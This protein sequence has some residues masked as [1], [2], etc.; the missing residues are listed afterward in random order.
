MQCE[1]NAGLDNYKLSVIIYA[2]NE[3][4]SLKK[5]ITQMVEGLQTQYELIIYLKNE[6]C[7][8]A[9]TLR[10]IT[11]LHPDWNIVCVHQNGSDILESTFKLMLQ[12]CS[13]THCIVWT[14]DNEIAVSSLLSIV[15]ISLKKRDALV[16]AA[17]FYKNNSM[18]GYGVARMLVRKATNFLV[19]ILYR[20]KGKD[21]FSIYQVFP[22]NFL[23]EMRFSAAKNFVYEST[24]VP[25]K[26]NKDYIEIPTDF[27]K[28]EGGKSN[29]SYRF[30][31]K[32]TG[33]YIYNVLK[34]WLTPKRKLLK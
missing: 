12:R 26:L 2:N 10:E 19:C 14:A 18:K 4:D 22:R 5:T 34:I 27:Q 33:M 1:K 31:L 23:N 32:V 15:E 13:G 25:L 30:Y 8:A 24:L 21:F 29:F 16:C 20:K 6:N 17:K 7:P 11:A 9:K 28:R 3:T